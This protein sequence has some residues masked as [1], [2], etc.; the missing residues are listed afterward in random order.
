MHL[1]ENSD[2]LFDQ[3]PD[4][5]M[6]ARLGTRLSTNYAISPLAPGR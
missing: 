2:T 3:L 6:V 4:G 5:A 1:Y